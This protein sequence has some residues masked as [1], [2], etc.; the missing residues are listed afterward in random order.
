M[1]AASGLAARARLNGAG[2]N[3]TG[4]L[5][6]LDEIVSSGITP[7]ERLLALYHGA[8]NGDV[9]HIYAAKSF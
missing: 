1:A 3:E 6:P 7:A 8:W 9:S 2:D 5:Q 4:Y